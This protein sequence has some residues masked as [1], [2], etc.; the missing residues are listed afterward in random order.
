M[1]KTPFLIKKPL[2]FI[3]KMKSGYLKTK[4]T[5]EKVPMKTK[6]PGLALFLFLKIILTN[7][8][9]LLMLIIIKNSKHLPLIIII[10]KTPNPPIKKKKIIRL[11]SPH[12]LLKPKLSLEADMAVLNILSFVGMKN[13]RIVLWGN[14][15]YLFRGL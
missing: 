2:S 7:L 8:S 9:K 14:C 12:F 13:C 4:N 11:I 15:L 5:K 3:S 1:P 6:N 10:R